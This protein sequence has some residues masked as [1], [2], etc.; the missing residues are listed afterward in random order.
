MPK[1][2]IKEKVVAELA[3]KNQEDLEEYDNNII[4]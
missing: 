1:V 3:L 4:L 2:L